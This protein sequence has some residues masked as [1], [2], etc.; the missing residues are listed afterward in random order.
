MV[1]LGAPFLVGGEQLNLSPRIAAT[2][3]QAG[4]TVP[5]LVQRLEATIIQASQNGREPVLNVPEI[6]RISVAEPD[7]RVEIR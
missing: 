4:D 2:L 1:T 7:N 3:N 6:S 5:S